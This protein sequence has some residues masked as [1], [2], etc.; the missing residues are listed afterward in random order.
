MK[1]AI[2]IGLI[3]CMKRLYETFC[4][5][6]GL[7]HYMTSR[8]LCGLQNSF[9]ILWNIPTVVSIKRGGNSCKFTN[10]VHLIGIYIH[11]DNEF[12]YDRGKIIGY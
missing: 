1:C 2:H 4:I 6:V 7:I 5:H 11:I 10:Y 9:H 12:F 3:A 8:V